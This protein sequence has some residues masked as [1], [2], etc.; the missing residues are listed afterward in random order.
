M[1]C[2][3]EKDITG[4]TNTCEGDSRSELLHTM[5]TW[6]QLV[7]KAQQEKV[8]FSFGAFLELLVHGPSVFVSQ[9]A[10]W[11]FCITQET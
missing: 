5:L 7:Q 3:C 6:A 11:V 8:S 2:S 1:L 4:D 9:M 10:I